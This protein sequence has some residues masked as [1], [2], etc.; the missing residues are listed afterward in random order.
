MRSLMRSAVASLLLLTTPVLAQTYEPALIPPQIN[1]VPTT[2]TPLQLGDDRTAQVSLGFDFPYW[3][4][5]FNS[6]WVSSNGFVSFQSS[7]HLCCNGYPLEQAQR[8]TIYGFWTDLISYS[9]NPFYKRGEGSILFGWYGTTEYGT[10]N[11][12]TF[13]IGLFDD[14]KIQFN[15][16]SLTSLTYHQATAGIT[17]PGQAD[18]IQLFLGRDTQFLK[19]QSGV[20]V[21]YVP[22]PPPEPEPVVPPPPSVDPTPSVAPDPAQEAAATADPVAEEV[23]IAPEPTPVTEEV[24]Q[25]ALVAVVAAEEVVAQAEEVIAEEPAAA[26]KDEEVKAEEP[27]SPDQL[28]ALAASGPSSGAEQDETKAAAQDPSAASGASETARVEGQTTQQAQSISDQTVVVTAEARRDRNVE[29]FK[30]EAVEDADLFARETVLQSSAQ[31]VA[32]LAQADA[33][34]VQQFGEQKTTETMGTTYT[35]GPAEGTNTFAPS[36][37]TGM[38]D[39]SSPVS[40]TQQIELL[41]MGGMQRE[42]SVTDGNDTQNMNSQDGEKMAQLGQAPAGF[43][44]YT[45]ARIPDAPFYQPRDIYKGRRIPDANVALYRMMR[46][47]DA[48]WDEMVESQYEQ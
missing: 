8:N 21:P 27:L 48:R 25:E 31:S 45:Q 23:V 16:G 2:M 13:E 42:M 33:Q 37:V 29:F 10:N 40:Q 17:G 47:Q 36:P 30:L 7:A 12:L 28:A 11:T 22:P 46:G 44:S 24:V 3:D 38:V 26:T 35:L 41:G 20:L 4:Q 5:T 34:Y 14:G 43:A 15:F 1:G 18:N 19:N 39:T 32:F 9:G 6:A